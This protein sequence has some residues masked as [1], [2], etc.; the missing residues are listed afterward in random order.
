MKKVEMTWATPRD[1]VP[2]KQEGLSQIYGILRDGKYIGVG[3]TNNMH[4]RM[5]FYRS[6]IRHSRPDGSRVIQ[7]M[8]EQAAGEDVYRFQAE[9][10]Q[11]V[12]AGEAHAW[13][14]VWI[15][16]LRREGHP[17]LNQT[18][19]LTEKEQP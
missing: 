10:L 1:Q 3:L 16:K 2:K 8:Q 6:A 17:L 15:K 12:P 13:E 5:A 9:L 11:V 4:S 19:F 18:S 14:A 7:A